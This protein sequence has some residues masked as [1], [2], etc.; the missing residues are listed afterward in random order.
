VANNICDKTYAL[1]KGV[2]YHPTTS[3]CGAIRYLDYAV[4]SGCRDGVVSY[5][6]DATTCFRA[7]PVI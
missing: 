1:K 3:M 4:P 2:G 6:M 5:T 7:L